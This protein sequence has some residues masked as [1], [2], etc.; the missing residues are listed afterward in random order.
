MDPEQNSVF[1][2]IQ[3][4]GGRKTRT[5]VELCHVSLTQP[6]VAEDISEED[7]KQSHSWFMVCARDLKLSLHKQHGFPGLIKLKLRKGNGRL[8]IST[9]ARLMFHQGDVSEH[10]YITT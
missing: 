3:I 2:K 10:Q 8:A 1:K 7:D 4:C 6:V 5:D 9:I